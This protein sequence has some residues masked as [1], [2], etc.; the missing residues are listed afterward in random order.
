MIRSL[1]WEM[2]HLVSNARSAI[3]CLMSCG[4]QGDGNPLLLSVERNIITQVF[5]WYLTFHSKI[6]KVLVV[7]HSH[8]A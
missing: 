5:M 8:S 3:F 7:L 2:K 1:V 6:F 4:G